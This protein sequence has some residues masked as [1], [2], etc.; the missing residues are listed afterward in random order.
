MTGRII[1]WVR[2]AARGARRKPGFTLTAVL[3]LGLGIGA[4]T[5]ILSVVDGVVLRPLPWEEGHRLVAFGVTFPQREWVDGVDDLQHLAGVSLPNARYIAER[6]RTLEELS[7]LQVAGVLLPDVGEGPELATMARVTE[8]FFHVLGAGVE[9]GRLFAPEEYGPADVPPLLLSWRTWQTRFG[10]DPSIVGR[11]IRGV[12]GASSPVVVGVLAR[13]F[14]VP[15]SLAPTDIEFWEPLDPGHPR[16]ESRGSRSISMIAR[17]AS[18]ATIDDARAE[19]TALAAEIAETYPEGS[20]YPDGSHFGYGV[21]ALRDHL[22]GTSGRPLLVFLGA[23]ALLLLISAMNTANLLLVRTSDRMGEL[24]I[25][26]ALG[27]GRGALFGQVM[28]ESVLISLC[29]GILGVAVAWLGV[30]AFLRWAPALPRMDQVSVNARILV[31]TASVS[32]GS[33]I[34]VGLLPA[35]GAARNDP[36]KSMRPGSRGVSSGS[37]RL[38]SALVT[39]QLGAALMLGIGASVLMHSFVRVASVDPGFSPEGLVSFRLATKRPGAP[40]VEWA[41][42]DE[43]LQAVNEE[44]PGLTSVAGT[45][46]LPFEDPNWAPS[47]LFPG[48]AEED[49]RVGIAGYA[50]TPGYFSTIGQEVLAGRA[51]ETGDGPDGEPVVLVNRALVARDFQDRQALGATVVVGEERMARRVVGIVEDAVVRRAE[52]GPSP[53]LY[54]PYTQQAWPWVKVVVRSERDFSALA[55]DLRRAAATVSPIVPIQSLLRLEDRIH[56]TETAPRFQALLVA[57]FAL[58]ALL[59]AAVGL[60]GTLAHAVGRRRREIGIRMALGAEPERVVVL[61]V[62]QAAIITGVGAVLGLSG[63]ALVSGVLERFLFDIPALDPMGFGV[64]L[65]VL[66]LATGAAVLRPALRAGRVDV[67]RSLRGE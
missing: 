16:F 52:E 4:T 42:W 55:P 33:G 19:L 65:G 45:S 18:G 13:D 32:V 43:T 25:R 9:L 54:V 31:L 11:S 67:V 3:T 41:A 7:G 26:R 6:T 1:R 36:A 49:M 17:L 46:N 2:E 8:D 20:V 50:I 48:E 61:V 38:R 24:G 62:R 22:V 39:A 44:L 10:G 35:A 64:G 30:E 28:S 40:D 34:L 63:A 5:T 21:N 66:A 23:A 12:E 59:L 51:F 58:A 53:A 47:L 15:E 57:S 14:R 37:G 29:G 27:A 60:Y 56:A